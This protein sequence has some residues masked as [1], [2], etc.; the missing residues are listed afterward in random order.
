MIDILWISNNSK[1]NFI[2][3]EVIKK[4][5]ILNVSIVCTE[6]LTTKNNFQQ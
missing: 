6:S 4:T 5:Y 3:N 1:T 2:L